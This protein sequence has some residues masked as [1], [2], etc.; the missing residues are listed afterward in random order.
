MPAGKGLAAPQNDF[1]DT[2]ARKFQGTHDNFVLG[3]ARAP[4]Y[5]IVYCSD[6]F[7]RLT[8]FLRAKVMSQSCF[9]PFLIGPDT[10]RDVAAKIS[11]ALCSRRELKSRLLLYRSDGTA[12]T[13]LLDITP[14]KNENGEVVLF[15]VSHKDVSNEQGIVLQTARSKHAASR[16]RKVP[17]SSLKLSGCRDSLQLPK[18]TG[19]RVTDKARALEAKIRLPEYKAQRAHKARWI[20]PHYCLLKTFWDW[21]ILLGTFYIAAIVP[22]NAA[23]LTLYNGNQGSRADSAGGTQKHTIYTDVI[24]ELLFI[25]DI[26]FNFRT[27]FVGKSSQVVYDTKVIALHYVKTWFFMDL[28]AAIPFDILV[29]FQVTKSTTIPLMKLARL[30]RL[31]HVIHKIGRYAQYSAAVLSLLMVAYAL[32]CHWMACFW[33][34]IG[35]FDL[36]DNNNGFKNGWLYSLAVSSEQIIARNDSDYGTQVDV[37]TLASSY[38]TSLY[39][40]T[41]I[42]TS[43]GF[44]NVAANTNS[45]KMFSIV[46]MMIGALMHALVFGNVVAIIQRM[47]ARKALYYIKSHDLEEFFKTHQ[48]PKPLRTRM[49]DFFQTMWSTNKG[50]EPNDI[51]KDFPEELKSDVSLHLYKDFLSLSPFTNVNPGCMK[52]LA[53]NVKTS[54]S[55][56]GEIVLARG[57][58]VQYIYLIANGS[59]E[60]LKNDLV[61]AILGKGDLFA[62]YIAVDDLCQYA[63]VKSGVSAR[64][65]T[66]CT[67]QCLSTRGLADV[68]LH[69]PESVKKII[70]VLKEELT[71]NLRETPDSEGSLASPT[72]T[73][74]SET[75][76][77][78]AGWQSGNSTLSSLDQE[79]S[80]SISE[81]SD[82]STRDLPLLLSTTDQMT[83]QH[84]VFTKP[85]KNSRCQNAGRRALKGQAAIEDLLQ[86]FRKDV[87]SLKTTL[88]TMSDALHRL[89]GDAGTTNRVLHPLALQPPTLA[90]LEAKMEHTEKAASTPGTPGYGHAG[91]VP[92][93]PRRADWARNHAYEDYPD[94]HTQNGRPSGAYQ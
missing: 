48:I 23:F 14:I 37:P 67:L 86:D 36:R 76:R 7:C 88:K 32:V 94:A 84:A 27:T 20:I 92:G 75:Y 31:S 58:A 81:P 38:L 52:M 85:R 2:I 80:K 69:Y 22:F 43:V 89:H 10:D 15:F 50:I 70:D 41:T 28:L 1:L 51:L 46:A 63:V 62:G 65:L 40:T 90:A 12:F 35:Y 30:L 16:C 87:R 6:G 29:A 11:H 55:A 5:P 53:L 82:Y 39:F 3:N 57:D 19:G 59:L 25:T 64:S 18:T 49:N 54:F 4:G 72:S 8:G 24:V 71:F 78:T 44:G 45:E 13:C 73:A 93:A 34:V 56:P 91:D 17:L 66:Y 33:F 74:T 79:S 21:L 68:M 61:V 42:L 83:M 26:A 9:C 60:I 77:G 47:Y